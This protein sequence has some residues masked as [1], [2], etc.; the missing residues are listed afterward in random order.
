MAA[1]LRNARVP[2]IEWLR[3]DVQKT[4]APKAWLEVSLQPVRNEEGL[5]PI[6]DLTST[7]D[8]PSPMKSWG[9]KRQ[10]RSQA[11][12]VVP[13]SSSELKSAGRDGSESA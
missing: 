9:G 3:N 4:Q 10:W 2:E 5:I 1:L 8:L 12:P 7:E 13:L 6:F 11:L